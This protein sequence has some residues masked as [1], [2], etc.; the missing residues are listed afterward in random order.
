MQIARPHAFGEPMIYMTYKEAGIENADKVTALYV[1]WN[2]VLRDIHMD[3]VFLTEGECLN[4][5]LRR[6]DHNPALVIARISG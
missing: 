3:E 5:L 2:R 1:V 4:R 6:T